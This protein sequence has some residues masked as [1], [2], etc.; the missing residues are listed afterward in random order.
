MTSMLPSL[1][2]SAATSGNGC[3]V[4]RR[5][6]TTYADDETALRHILDA[7]REAVGLARGRSHADLDEDHLVALGFVKLVESIGEAATRLTAD[8]RDAHPSIS[9]TDIVNMRHRLVHDYTRINLDIVWTVVTVKLPEL[10]A[11]VEPLV[12]PWT[13]DDD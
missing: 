7:A 4:R 9:W 6:S 11:H 5:R 1:R 2:P 12:P 8:F 13:E 10:I 3:S